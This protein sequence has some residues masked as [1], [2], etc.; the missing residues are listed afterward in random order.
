M[1][2]IDLAYEIDG[3]IEY[4]SIKEVKLT[5]DMTTVERIDKLMTLKKSQLQDILGVY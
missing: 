3:M 2:K 5:E 1:N 4:D